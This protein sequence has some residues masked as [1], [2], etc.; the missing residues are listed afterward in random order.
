MKVIA[1][2]ILP[3]FVELVLSHLFSMVD[4]AMLGH[5]DISSVA[6]SSVG[7]TMNPINIII[8]VCQAFCIGITAAVAWSIGA[9]KKEN[10]RTV[11][12]ETLT[13]SILIGIGAGLLVFLLSY[14]HLFYH[15]HL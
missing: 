3:A 1:V 6:I 13:L 14:P 11:A 12:R 10:A 5:T 7:L 2:I 4:I 9:G 8:G 15:Y